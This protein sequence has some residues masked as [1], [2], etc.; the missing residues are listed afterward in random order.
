VPLS[1]PRCTAFRA[2]SNCNARLR[3]GQF[4][5]LISAARDQSNGIDKNVNERRRM[6]R[7]PERK[8]F[9]CPDCQK[10]TLLSDTPFEDICPEC[11]SPSGRVISSA[12]L[13]RRIK[14]LASILRPSGRDRPKR[15]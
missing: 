13:E 4:R 3:R 11:G 7:K 6:A 8:F 15:Q 1:T 14:D 10:A 12:E 2:R 9:E 5:E